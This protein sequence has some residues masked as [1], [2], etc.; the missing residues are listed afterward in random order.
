MWFWRYRSSALLQS[1]S[2]RR[3]LGAHTNTS[4]DGKPSRQSAG[5]LLHVW[6]FLLFFFC[7]NLLVA[8]G[9]NDGNIGCRQAKRAQRCT[10]QRTNFAYIFP[11]I[12]YIFVAI[13]FRCA[14][15]S[16]SLFVI[17]FR[18]SKRAGQHNS[19]PNGPRQGTTSQCSIFSLYFFLHPCAAVRLCSCFNEKI[20]N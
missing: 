1:N 16:H 7:L 20:M 19:L 2:A 5:G 12:R 15:T 17:F 6:F 14:L 4:A 10:R 18:S 8:A 11:F 3:R 13:S 9:R